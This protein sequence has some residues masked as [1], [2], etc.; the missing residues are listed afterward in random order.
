[1]GRIAIFTDDPGWHGKMLKLAFAKLGFS[2]EFVSLTECKLNLQQGLTPVIIPSFEQTLP[3]AVFVRG[4]PGGSLEEVVLYLDILHALKL[5]D[6]PVYNDGRAIERS[7]DKAMTS[8][9]LHQAGLPT[10]LTWVLRNRADAIQV[11]DH[12]LKNGHYLITKPLF[13]S[14]GEGIRRIEKMTDLFWLAASNGVY[15]FQRFVH[16]AGDGFSDYR[17]FVID[18]QA[19]AIMRRRGKSWLNNVARGAACEAIDL[20]PAITE[21]AVQ[22]AKA[23]AM[24]YAG[25]DIIQDK[26]GVYLVIEVNSIPAW[27]GLESVSHISIASLL[28][29]DLVNRYIKCG[30]S[31]AIAAVS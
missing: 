18:D 22:A 7:V 24:D 15:Y 3:D 21:L 29:E 26:A 25:V 9:L 2:S 11:A 14:Q 20:D 17:V 27:K 23:L 13:G 4:V 6:I 10:P 31:G 5:L 1:M 19:V 28:A 16:C 30:A 8:F 12:E